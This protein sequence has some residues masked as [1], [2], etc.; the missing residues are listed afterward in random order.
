VNKIRTILEP[1]R[2]TEVRKEK[3]KSKCK[4]KLKKG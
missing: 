2:E 1:Q 4:E 3:K